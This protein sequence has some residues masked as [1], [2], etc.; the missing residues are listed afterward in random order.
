MTEAKEPSWHKWT[1]WG[2]TLAALGLSVYGLSQAAT[3]ND[4]AT[5]ANK[6]A[7]ESNA[8][9]A[10]GVELSAEPVIKIG[11]GESTVEAV[12]GILTITIANTGLPDI[13][14]VAVSHSFFLP[15]RTDAASASGVVA[16]RVKPMNPRRRIAVPELGAG[17]AVTVPVNVR[18]FGLKVEAEKKRLGYDRAFG[19]PILAFVIEY[20]RGVDGKRGC[21]TKILKLLSGGQF[22]MSQW[23]P[24]GHV[25]WSW[26]FLNKAEA[27]VI[28]LL[29]KECR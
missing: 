1:N 11:N 4:R 2:L 21:A 20:A 5:E 17:E 8:L 24:W 7:A 6:R 25:D 14:D 9:A 13:V 29:P 22:A 3:A 16:V 27:Q 10:K 23:E 26:D 12:D 18:Q 15:H 28:A 19:Q